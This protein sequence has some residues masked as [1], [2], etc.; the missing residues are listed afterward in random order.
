M[1]R[2]PETATFQEVVCDLTASLPLTQPPV[3]RAF[4]HTVPEGV[5]LDSG[6]APAGCG[7]WQ[8]AT[9]RTFHS[10]CAIGVY[11]H[12]LEAPGNMQTDLQDALTVFSELE[13][14]R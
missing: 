5:M 11:T 2:N 1:P 6:A 10:L 12:R 3:E 13:Y 7:F 8:E 4:T 9:N 14:V